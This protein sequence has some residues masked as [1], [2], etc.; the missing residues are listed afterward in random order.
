MRDS[1][2]G[3]AFQDHVHLGDNGG[4]TGERLLIWFMGFILAFGLFVIVP[5]VAITTENKRKNAPPLPSGDS[6]EVRR[7]LERMEAIVAAQQKQ[8]EG[9]K[10]LLHVNILKMEDMGGLQLPSRQQD[11]GGRPELPSE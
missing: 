9:L 6:P 10:E 5:I 11:A 1:G 8:I 3:T 7:R 2:S 4:G